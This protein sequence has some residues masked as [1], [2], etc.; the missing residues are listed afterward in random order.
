MINRRQPDKALDLIDE[1]CARIVIQT[2]SQPDLARV[3]DVTAITE[4]L[5][6]WTGIP[7]SELGTND[8]LK[9]A[10][11]Q[12][13]LQKRVIGQD[14]AL[15]AVSEAI[16]SNRAG[17]SDPNR[18][19]GVFLFLGPSGVGKTE[20]AKALAAFLFGSEDALIRLDMS[21]F[22]GEHTSAR[23]V[24]SPPG[25]KDSQ[26]GGQLTE[27]L[28]RRPY[29]VV[30]LDEIEKA[31]PEVFDLFLQVFDDGRLTDGRGMTVDARHAVW[32]MTGNVGTAEASRVSLGFRTDAVRMPLYDQHIKRVFRPEFLNRLDEIVIFDP[33][34]DASLNTILDLRLAEL[35]QRLAKQQISLQLEPDARALLINA[36]TD[37]AN[38][39]RPLRRAVERLLIRPLSRKLLSDFCA[40][41]GTVIVSVNDDRLSFTARQ[42][43]ANGAS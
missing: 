25:Y 5:T 40:P 29:S 36:G 33:L 21:E 7:I 6:E 9:F 43:A 8:R 4:I 11:M 39:A 12:E 34:D 18:P 41:G 2:H 38:G 30:L 20:L 14:H 16:Q 32:I 13:S 3:V 23:L 28:N 37:P 15:R 10:N 1:A 27:A 24:G 35:Y 31:T 26:R 19:V 17:L 42:P 22:Y